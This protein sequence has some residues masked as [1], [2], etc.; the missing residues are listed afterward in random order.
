MF[1]SH[2][3]IIDAWPSLEDFSGDAGVSCNTAKQMRKR[4]NIHSEYWPNIVAGAARRG[5]VQ[6]TYK[7]LAESQRPRRA[8]SP[9]DERMTSAASARAA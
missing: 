2:K 4:N 3:Q 6:V 1:T 5:I 7:A 9:N 8:E